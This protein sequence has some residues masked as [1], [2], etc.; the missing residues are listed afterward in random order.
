MGWAEVAHSRAR[1]AD[2]APHGMPRRH[3]GE[4]AADVDGGEG[5]G[6]REPRV[7]ANGGSP[8]RVSGTGR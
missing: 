3:G 7:P 5:G 4:V 6:A 8:A 1:G 2:A